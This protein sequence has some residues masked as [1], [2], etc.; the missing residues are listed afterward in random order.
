[1][2]YRKFLCKRV[3]LIGTPDY[4]L[5]NCPPGHYRSA[6]VVRADET[7]QTLEAFDD[8]VFA[9]SDE[10]SQSGYAAAYWHVKP[11]RPWFENRLLTGQ[12][13]GS[14]RAVAEG[15]ADLAS[16]DA[17]S[18]RLMCHYEPW[19]SS[20]RVLDWTASSPGLPYIS[21]IGIDGRAM[22]KGINLAIADLSHDDRSRLGIRQLVRI[23]E[24]DYLAIPNPP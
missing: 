14:A 24:P 10:N 18:W 3:A 5:E 2:P 9:Y 1:M 4:G 15:R 19:T 11:R 8:A 22:F 7:R 12:H 23:P 16:I 20:L 21:R 13:I 6:I 17:V